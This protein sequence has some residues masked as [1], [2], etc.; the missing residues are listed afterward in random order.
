MTRAYT[1]SRMPGPLKRRDDDLE[2]RSTLC[3]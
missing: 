1:L 2:K 3:Q